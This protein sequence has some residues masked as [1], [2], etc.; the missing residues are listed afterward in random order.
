M[1]SPPPPM[2]GTPY[3]VEAYAN[4]PVPGNYYR[5]GPGQFTDPAIQ[6]RATISLV[7]AIIS[8]VVCW[9]PGIIPIVFAIMA[10]SA[11]GRG[12]NY[13]VERNAKIANVWSIIVLSVTGV[14]ILV[15]AGV[16]IYLVSSGQIR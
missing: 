4:P 8:L 2:E 9:L 6:K 7:L 5:Q 14:L 16:M 10:Q 15:Y 13:G 11:L 3:R 1:M 12:D